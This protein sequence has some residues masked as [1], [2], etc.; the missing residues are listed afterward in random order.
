VE[1]KYIKHKAGHF[2]T[3]LKSP[4]S[5]LGYRKLLNLFK[6]TRP[7]SRKFGF[8]RGKPIDRYYIENFLKANRQLIT[9]AVLEIADSTYS[10]AFGTAV[11]R[12]EVLG[13]SP[14]QNTTIIGDLCD[15]ASLPSGMI[16]CFIC[17]Q[18]YNFVY[19]FKAAI[20]G[21]KSLL[22]PGGTLLATV[23]GL[24]QISRYDMDHWGDYWRF[25]T[26]SITKAFEEV[27]G[28]GNVVVDCHGNCLAACSFLQ[29]LSCHEV[30][31]RQLDIKDEDY[32]ILITIVA[33]K[34]S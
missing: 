33:R 26:L 17:T 29:G 13:Y 23:S 6:S 25:T 14:T 22:K 12:Y 3:R 32:P 9:G 34:R 8:D 31:R 28:V 4:G 24:S 7:V 1:W 5:L 27:F 19:D 11:S 18:T 30:S 21:S 2:L 16:D 20:A 15:P 10:K